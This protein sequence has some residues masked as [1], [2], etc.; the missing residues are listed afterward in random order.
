MLRV[1]NE[2]EPTTL[3]P[4]YRDGMTY[5][6]SAGMLLAMRIFS[7]LKTKLETRTGHAPRPG[8]GRY[9]KCSRVIRSTLS[10]RFMPDTCVRMVELDQIV[11][12]KEFV[13]YYTA[14]TLAPAIRRSVDTL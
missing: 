3:K 6:T 7:N 13:D 5:I 8:A 1:H 14:P 11:A 10:M 4:A 9:L 2:Q 12:S